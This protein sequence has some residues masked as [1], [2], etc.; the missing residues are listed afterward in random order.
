M[1][2][3]A[4]RTVNPNSG[5][6]LNTTRQDN[7][8]FPGYIKHPDRSF[9]EA[10]GFHYQIMGGTNKFNRKVA[11]ANRYGCWVNRE[12]FGE[13]WKSDAFCDPMD[14]VNRAPILYNARSPSETHRRGGRSSSPCAPQRRYT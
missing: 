11:E 1:A 9:W 12:E 8:N 6:A 3:D 5:H 14:E 13:A 10:A 2:K 4:R 7:P